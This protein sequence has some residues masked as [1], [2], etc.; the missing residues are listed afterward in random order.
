M[1][2][3]L[4][5]PNKVQNK[6]LIS[7]ML[8]QIPQVFAAFQ[9]KYPL[10]TST[11]YRRHYQSSTGRTVAD[12]AVKPIV[13]VSFLAAVEKYVYEQDSTLLLKCSASHVLHMAML[14]DTA[15]LIDFTN[16]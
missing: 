1:P 10:H 4:D 13:P 7:A 12:I 16:H 9:R 15:I 14:A 2:R 11:S 5:A 3:V 6:Q 8:P